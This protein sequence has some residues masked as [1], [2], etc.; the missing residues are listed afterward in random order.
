MSTAED[1]VKIGQGRLWYP[2]IREYTTTAAHEVE[3]VAGHSLQ[4]RNSNGLVRNSTWEIGLSKTATSVR[5][6]PLYGH[7]SQ[8]RNPA[9][10]HSSARLS[11]GKQTR[12]G[13]T[14]RIKKWIETHLER[15][16]IG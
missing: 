13:D 14:I 2:L 11:I 15:K 7:A 1:L 12:I 8:N 10:N 16:P 6:R 3:T 9:G 4:F 5:A